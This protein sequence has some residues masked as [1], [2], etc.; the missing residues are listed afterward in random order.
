MP[1][2]D[3][4]PRILNPKFQDNKDNLKYLLFA[5][6]LDGTLVNNDKEITPATAN[7]VREI[8]EM[9]M[10]VAVV[11]GR[12]T[13]GCEHIAEQLQLAKY[14]GYII[15]YNGAKVTS[16]RD[17][18]VLARSTISRET[19][20]ELYDFLKPYPVVMMT[21]TRREI[22]TEDASNPYVKQESIV[23]NGMPIR[24]VPNLVEALKRDPYKCGI[25]GDEEVISK[26]AIELQDRFKG[27]LNAILSGPIFIEAMNPYVDKGKALSFLISELGIDRKSV[28][29]I[30]DANNDL[31]MLQVAGL[32][33]AMAN[34][35]EN[36]KQVADYVT[37]SNEEEGIQHLLNKFVLH[38]EEPAGHPEVD[39]INSMQKNTLMENLGMKCTRLEEGYVECTMPVDHRTCQ[40]MGILHGGA[41]LA[42]AETAAGYGSVYLLH[43]DEGMVGMQVSG[44]HVHSARVGNL[45]TAKARI[46][47]RGRS[48]HLWDV[49]IYTEMG[50]LVSS[51]RVLNSILH[52]R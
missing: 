42:L 27:K 4:K 29:A 47:H 1:V 7:A 19:V 13:Y 33:V 24:E 50:T 43:S 2:S 15:S 36:I 11:S 30:G 37:T 34:A 46:I 12:P 51:I 52:K 5:V 38:P 32:G 18:D 49:E 44:S 40:P 35:N 28:I 16:C 41:S 26:L 22:I 6:D 23:D 8:L 3:T 17:N 48:T 39:F 45:L 10:T 21:Y 20:R 31:P 9:G 25:A 14:G